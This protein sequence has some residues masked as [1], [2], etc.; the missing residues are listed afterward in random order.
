MSEGGVMARQYEVVYIFDSSLE[1][2][3]VNEILERFHKL[4]ECAEYPEPITG[5]SH[6]GK[7]TLAYPIK[8]KELGYYVVAQFETDASLLDEFERVVKLEESVVRHLIVI[9]EGLATVP[10][11]VAPPSKDDE[12]EDED[13]DSPLSDVEDED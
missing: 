12:D 5:L 2:E 8:N 10:A 11:G 3:Q 7:R 1:E 6:W 4:L 9:N 13:E